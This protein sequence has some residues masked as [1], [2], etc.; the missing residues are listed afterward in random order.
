[1]FAG[2]T[3]FNQD[4]SGWDTS[5]VTNM[6]FM[7]AGATSFNCDI[8]KW[9]TSNVQNMKMMFLYNST[10]NQDISG[11]DTSSVTDM[12]GMFKNASAFN[13]D[14]SKWDTSS[15]SNMPSMFENAVAFD[16]YPGIANWNFSNITPYT[17]TDSNEG[18]SAYWGLYNFIYNVGTNNQNPSTNFSTFIQNLSKNISL[19]Y[20]ID[21]GYTGSENNI[22]NEDN[23]GNA[24]L[25]KL[26]TKKA[27]Q[28]A[29]LK[30]ENIPSTEDR[31]KTLNGEVDIA[32]TFSFDKP[33]V[34]AKKY[35]QLQ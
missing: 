17:Y 28:H 1:M 30:Q 26:N 4:I 6:S 35:K 24:A 33:K 21:L 18:L 8:T 19:P 5:S 32:S 27:I 3:S 11:W 23:D 15:V 31:G 10:F 16:K 34:L 9:N 29:T 7:F 14:I 25:N 13:Q 2:A 12:S 22:D 20:N